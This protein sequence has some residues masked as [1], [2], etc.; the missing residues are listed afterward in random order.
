MGNWTNIIFGSRKGTP[1]FTF[2][3]WKSHYE[4]R[5][6]IATHFNLKELQ[7]EAKKAS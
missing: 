3:E 6:I 5:P 2:E 1:Q 4:K 7:N